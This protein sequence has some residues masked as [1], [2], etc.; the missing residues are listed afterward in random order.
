MSL[1]EFSSH[2]GTPSCKLPGRISLSILTTLDQLFAGEDRL[3]CEPLLQAARE[4][5]LLCSDLHWISSLLHPTQLRWS[6]GGVEYEIEVEIAPSHRDCCRPLKGDGLVLTCESLLQAAGKDQ[7]E[8]VRR[9]RVPQQHRI[10]DCDRDQRGAG[11]HEPLR[12]PP[13]WCYYRLRLT[14]TSNTITGGLCL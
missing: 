2:L 13:S 6:S 8:A 5:Q 4:D 10:A 12:G 11:I 9:P 14:G 7:A 1:E 3:T